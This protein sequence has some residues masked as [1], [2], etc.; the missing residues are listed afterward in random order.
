[1]KKNFSTLGILFVAFA[2]MAFTSCSSDD[3]DNSSYVPPTPS[4]QS[5]TTTPETTKAASGTLNL[6]FATTDET[7]MMGDLTVNVTDQS[8]KTTSTTM[9]ASELKTRAQGGELVTNSGAPETYD[10][11]KV[12][13]DGYAYANDMYYITGINIAQAPAEY[14]VS[15]SYKIKDNDANMKKADVMFSTAYASFTTTEGQTIYPSSTYSNYLASPAIEVST[16]KETYQQYVA[17]YDDFSYFT[18]TV[19]VAK[20][21][22]VTLKK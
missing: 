15:I 6:C 5:K 8:G 7:L 1:M 9:Q 14:K 17:I 10:L 18:R 12:E 22:S 2:A 21:G 11:L 20:D 16:D 19:V 3:S 4:E 13:G